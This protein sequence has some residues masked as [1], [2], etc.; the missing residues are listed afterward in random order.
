VRAWARGLVGP[1]DRVERADY[2]G[3][4]ERRGEHRRHLGE[5]PLGDLHGS[6]GR[7]RQ[8]AGL[9][10]GRTYPVGLLLGGGGRGPD[11]V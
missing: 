5:V 9:V 1:G 8:L 3:L 10:T 2:L 7:R 4:G 11:L 6:V